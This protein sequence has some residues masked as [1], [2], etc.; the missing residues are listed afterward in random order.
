MTGVGEA[1]E[2]AMEL[3]EPTRVAAA[4]LATFIPDPPAAVLG[5]LGDTPPGTALPGAAWF[6]PAPPLPAVGVLPPEAVAPE[7]AFLEPQPPEPAPSAM[8][9]VLLPE[10]ATAGSL[11]RAPVPMATAM[12]PM[13]APMPP[14]A[15][16]GEP[17]ARGALAALGALT[18]ERLLGALE[19]A[20]TGL[21]VGVPDAVVE[22]IG[23]A[24]VSTSAST[25]GTTTVGV[26]AGGGDSALSLSGQLLDGLLPGA[27]PFLVELVGA[28][29]DTPTVTQHVT[30]VPE[31]AAAAMAAHHGRVH[32]A[33]A[34]AAATVMLRAAD[35]ATG[36][37][38]LDHANPET[39]VGAALGATAL[40]LPGRAMPAGWAAARL[41]EKQAAFL[42]PR[43]VHLQLRPHRSRFALLESAVDSVSGPD[44]VPPDVSVPD[45][46]L[47]S[48]I[49]GGFVVHTGTGDVPV[50]VELD[51]AAEDPGP[52]ERDGWDEVVE[53]SYVADQGSASL[54]AAAGT[55]WPPT[56]ELTFPGPGAVRV[57]V[58]ARDRGS[59]GP[60]RFA[61]QLWSAPDA[62]EV[63]VHRRAAPA[64]PDPD[65]PRGRARAA[66][67]ATM[68]SPVTRT[69]FSD[70]SAWET[71]RAA[72]AAPIDDNGFGANLEFVD[73]TAFNGL[74][75]TEILALSTDTWA[76]SQ[77]CLV[78]VDTVTLAS[79]E[80]PLL[81]V[82]LGREPGRAFRCV[83]SE[84]PLIEVN[85]AIANMDFADFADAVQDDGVFRGF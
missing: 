58:H 71:V 76:A 19:L 84:F 36:E 26:V 42:L 32:L 69:D 45:N 33:V 50:T 29:Y 78:V 6:A 41:A 67:L 47:V 79:P 51:V 23:R 16:A 38:M 5:R 34:V 2:L 46:G 53:V 12:P 39:I 18:A 75:P 30:A 27:V 62:P 48:P 61:L 52:S 60:E 56:G 35:R 64:E 44:G 81:I 8:P 73:D 13:M 83:A 57:R 43:S 7:P 3:A 31:D 21:V 72:I 55:V 70:Q 63:V 65:G 22:R 85:L 20:V 59:G 9:G 1:R 68:S 40:L 15:G 10:A 77:A 49:P 14:S 24:V 66:L 74:S 37:A 28:L 25:D 4:E 54:V 17:S 11:P 80:W 82:E